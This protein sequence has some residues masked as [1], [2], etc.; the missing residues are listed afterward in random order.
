L[1]WPW[2]SST[3]REHVSRDQPFVSQYGGQYRA[4]L[5]KTWSVDNSLSLRF[6]NRIRHIERDQTQ[7]LRRFQEANEISHVGVA[8]GEVEQRRHICPIGGSCLCAPP[9]QSL[10]SWH[11][12]RSL[13]SCRSCRSCRSSS[14][15][16]ISDEKSVG[17]HR[18]R[19]N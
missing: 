18:Q 13:Q 7:T 3:V 5:G 10:R 1:D 14:S 12:L 9:R 11:S 16:A 4:F 15:A 8:L 19:A 17:S 6:C 2:Q